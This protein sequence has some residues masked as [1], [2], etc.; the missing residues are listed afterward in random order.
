MDRRMA[1]AV[2]IFQ[3]FNEAYFSCHIPMPHIR[4]S[5]RM[6]RCAGKVFLYPWEMI[7]SIPYHDRYGWDDELWDTVGHETIHLWL[8]KIQHPS[9][10][11]AEFK[12]ICA[13][14]GVTVWA[15]AMPRERTRYVYV[16]PAC[17]CRVPRCRRFQKPR[18]CG[19][20]CRKHN[21]GQYSPRFR[22]ILLYDMKEIENAN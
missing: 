21:G 19:Y 4:L 1:D 8:W 6:T 13:H 9:G 11:T 20:C 5:T 17:R 7:L 15:K 14:I 22:L 12:R 2:A 16:C 18:A 10:H 3:M